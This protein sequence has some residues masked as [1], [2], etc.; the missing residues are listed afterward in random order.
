MRVLTFLPRVDLQRRVEKA[1][2]SAQFVVDTVGSVQECPSSARFAQYDGMLLDSDALLFA[3]NFPQKLI[4]TNRGI[5][6]TLTCVTACPGASNDHSV[7]DGGAR[8]V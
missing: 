6:Y 5:G 2:T 3:R 7:R 8:A 4:Q 1:R